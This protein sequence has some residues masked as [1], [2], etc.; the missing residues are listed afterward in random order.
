MRRNR[1]SERCFELHFSFDRAST[2]RPDPLFNEGSESWTLF[3]SLRK[4][5]LITRKIP[6][7]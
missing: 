4:Y 7:L 1:A 2:N 5:D 6:V 3:F